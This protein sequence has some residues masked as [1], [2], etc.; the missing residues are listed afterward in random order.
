MPGDFLRSSWHKLKINS[1]VP[2]SILNYYLS[3]IRSNLERF[4][5]DFNDFELSEWLNNDVDDP[6]NYMLSYN[7]IIQETEAL[8]SNN[9][10]KM[11]D[12]ESDQENEPI[13]KK[14]EISNGTA[15]LLVDG[16]IQ[17]CNENDIDPN[18]LISIKKQINI[19]R[20]ENQNKL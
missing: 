1:N 6:G 5:L 2:V 18:T 20:V 15:A 10:P 17:Y 9:E 4:G 8:F 12:E 14:K 13:E 3:R 11:I 19:K 7:E 16:L